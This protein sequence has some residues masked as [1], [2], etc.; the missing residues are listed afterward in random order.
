MKASQV[1]VLTVS[2]GVLAVVIAPHRFN[3]DGADGSA[4]TWSET[5]PRLGESHVESGR[6][7]H[8][9]QRAAGADAGGTG[10]ILVD[11]RVGSGSDR[12]DRAIPRAQPKSAQ[13]ED[14]IVSPVD[15]RGI[16]YESG[17]EVRFSTDS[18][19]QVPERGNLSGQRG[20]I[21]FQ[22]E[23]GWSG[24]NQA[25][26]SLVEI[27]DGRVV[28]RKNVSF[29]RF[30]MKD[31]D[32]NETGTGFS[33]AEWEPGHP[34]DVTASW[35]A[36]VMSLSVDGRPAAEEHYTELFE[37]PP[38]TPVYVGTVAQDAPIAPGFLTNVVLSSTPLV[39]GAVAS[40][41]TESTMNTK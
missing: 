6:W 38:G 35:G 5:A 16:T 14:A 11:A 9:Q 22:F 41:S 29:L 39:P 3:G 33:I 32:G 17:R 4:P 7:I 36:G 26:A 31:D 10:A 40:R 27:G 1:I 18:R 20:T 23:P 30:E 8:R 2:L 19:F 34:Y 25:D 15:N 13:P 24:E 37:I 12:G 21:S 28:I